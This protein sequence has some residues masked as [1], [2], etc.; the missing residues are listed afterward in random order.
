MEH[1]GEIEKRLWSSADN[2]RANSNFAS[3]EYFLPV[4]GLIFLRHAYSRFLKVK[5]EIEPS[6]PTRGGKPRAL[7]KEDFSRKGAIFLHPEAIERLGVASA[8]DAGVRVLRRCKWYRE[9]DHILTLIFSMFSGGNKLQDVNR[10]GQDDALKRVL[11]SDRIPHATTIGKF[12][13][14]FGNDQQDKQ[15]QGLAELRDT[16]AAIQQDA[17]AMLPR[18]RRKVATLDWDSSIHE[19]YGQKKEGADFAYDNTWSYSALYGTLAE[20]GDVLYLGLREGYRHTSY[21]TKEV[22]PGTI[23]RVSKH[24]RQ[25]R[26]RADSG[27][28]SQALVKIC[29]QREVEFFIVAKQHRNLMNAVRE[30]PESHWKSFADSDLQADDRRRRRRRRANLKRKIAI[31]RKPNS[32]FKGAPEIAGMM[33]KPKSWNKARRYV[34]KRTPIVD[35]DDQQL[36]LDDGLRRYVYWIVVSLAH[37]PTGSLAANQAYFMIA[38]LAWNLKTW[39][40]NLLDLGDGAVMR[41]QRFRYLW[42]WQAGVV[43]MSGRNTVVLK[44]PAGEYF[45][46]FGVA[47]ARL[48]TL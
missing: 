22:L 8:I 20:T 7:T 27:Y 9:S 29:E 19:V 4:M 35:K 30:I 2:L 15:R 36:Y 40:L 3:N 6:L 17:F 26:M 31:R 24:F 12:L 14:R 13:W 44:L 28:Y 11:G 1:I 33:F 41:F 34:I 25:V 45:Q 23:E 32:R 39:M 48:A 37:I 16:T 38:A 43:A 42:I 10:L 5:A 46:R 18:E 21:G 47:M